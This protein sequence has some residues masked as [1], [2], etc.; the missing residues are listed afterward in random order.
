MRH[1][2][3]KTGR[4]NAFWVS[5]HKPAVLGVIMALVL[6]SC[7][8]K[9]ADPSSAA[10]GKDI[11]VTRIAKEAPSFGDEKSVIDCEYPTSGDTVLLQNVREWINEILGDTYEGNL[12]DS[13]TMFNFYG[14]RM[15]EESEDDERLTK[16]EIKK[17]YENDRIVTFVCRGYEYF[18]GA[19]HGLS[20]EIGATFRKSDGKTFTKNMIRSAR[21]VQP[22]IVE[23]LKDYFEVATDEELTDCLI[24][25][26]DSE[27]IPLPTANPW[28]TED[29]MTFCYMAYEIASYAAGQP[30][31][32]IPASDIKDYLTTVGKTFLE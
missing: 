17:V 3:S 30:S 2:D 32:V 4:K 18:N 10:D 16:T 21:E 22:F 14:Q 5:N 7:A 20:Y 8:H 31:F 9:S 6:G 29:G 25:S 24:L 27:Y 26:D 11:E 28:I 13:E 1:N 19:A 23:G 15:E 12:A